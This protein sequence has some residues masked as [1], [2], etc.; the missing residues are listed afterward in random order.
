V[1]AGR[2]HPL[3]LAV[4]SLAV[5]SIGALTPALGSGPPRVR[6]K[7]G[8]AT[9]YT[10]L[11]E[12]Q[13]DLDRDLDSMRATHAK[14]IRFDVAWSVIE[15]N[16][17]VY[18]WSTIDRLVDAAKAR[19]FKL[20]GT[21]TYTPAWAR[22]AGTDD[23]TAPSTLA[24]REAYGVFAAA[25]AARYAG[26]VSA[27]ELWNEENA[28][29]FWKPAPDPA[30]YRSLVHEA[31]TRMRAAVPDVKIV[32]GGL[33]AVGNGFGNIDP[34]FFLYNLYD[35][36]IGPD[37]GAVGL[38][39]TS[40]PYAPDDPSTAEWNILFRIPRIHDFLA[41]RGDGDKPIWV[42]EYGAPTSGYK[43]VSE[44]QQAEFV[45]EAIGQLARAGDYTGP[46]FWYTPR[47][48]GTDPA[49]VDQNYGIVRRDWTGKQSYLVFAALFDGTGKVLADYLAGL[50]W[51]QDVPG[52]TPTP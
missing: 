31:S 36:G 13:A 25:A 44:T 23:K 18:D 32:L 34:E 51:E 37:I 19:G 48:K 6:P 46:L 2:R 50:P 10:L 21:L 27:W 3:R 20:L 42:T 39:A 33:A 47:D 30:G 16:Q 29:P 11:Y 26:R 52:W 22:P 24:Q 17:G 9:A 38:H 45:V 8:F 41:S 49:D 40:Y 14:W 4:A 1:P 43:A 28:V 15:R 7:G 35:R 12:P 5:L